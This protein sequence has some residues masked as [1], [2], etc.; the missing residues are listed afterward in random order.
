MNGVGRD[1]KKEKKAKNK[2]SV[3]TRETVGMT[4]LLFSAVIFFICVTGSRLFGEIGVAITAFFLGIGGFMT[5]PVL[6]FMIYQS[7][8]LVF[9]RGGIAWGWKFL[10][11][12]LLVCAFSIVHVSTATRFFGGGYGAY[13][14]GCWGA[15]KNGAAGGT[16]GGVLLGAIVFPVQSLLSAAG[17]YVVFA[18]LSL[19]VVFFILLK[20]PLRSYV[21]GM[22]MKQQGRF[23][24]GRYN[25]NEEFPQESSPSFDDLALPVR[26]APAQTEQPARKPQPQPSN[27]AATRSFFSAKDSFDKN[28]KE[29]SKEILFGSDPKESYRNNL[30]FNS[31]SYFNSRERA[32]SVYRNESVSSGERT[33]SS[34]YSS[35]A[36]T[37]TD[38]VPR[39][40][41]ED[42]FASQGGYTYSPVNDITYSQTPSYRVEPQKTEPDRRDYYEHDVPYREEF[43]SSTNEGNGEGKGA[44]VPEREELSR[45]ETPF[46]DETPAEDIFTRMMCEP[47]RQKGETPAERNDDFSMRSLFSRPVGEERV[48]FREEETRQT[49]ARDFPESNFG[50]R[51]REEERG[52]PRDGNRIFSR[53]DFTKEERR[54]AADLFDDENDEEDF[55]SNDAPPS[56]QPSLRQERSTPFERR[57]SE[58][59]IAPSLSE[60]ANAPKPKRHIRR[61]YIAPDYALFTKYNDKISVP[62][63]EIERNSAA[64]E[65]CLADFRVDAKVV[66]VTC[67]ATV[68]RYDLE[69]PGNISVNTVVKRDEEIAMRLHASHGVNVFANR[70]NGTVAV[71][72]P[73]ETSATV[74]LRSLLYANEYVNAKPDSLMFVVGMD[75]EGKPVIGNIVKMKQLLVAGSTGSGKSVCLHSMLI[76]LI[77]KYSPED[78]RLILIDAKGE[79]SVYENLPHLMINEIISDAQKAIMALNWAIKEMERRYALFQQKTRSGV[80][81]RNIDEYNA[82][83]TQDEEKLCKIVIMVDELADLML[84]AKKDIEERIQRLTQKS[85]AAGLH[86]VLSTQRPSVDVITGVIKGN[87]PTRMALRVVQEVDSRTIIDESGAQKL[88]GNGDMLYRTE[89]MFNC[90]RVQGAFLSS[91]EVKSIVADVKKNNE[92]YFDTEV[93]DYINN[94]AQNAS[95]VSDDEL[96]EGDGEVGEQYVKALGMVVKLGT[97]SISL[98]QRKCNVGYNHAGKIIEWMELMGYIS[99]FDGKAKARTVLLTKEEYESKYG[100]LD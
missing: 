65:E 42:K 81:V 35:A 49:P 1:E 66:K 25:P 97:A 96:E 56:R 70:A 34:R 15:A 23:G 90:L 10:G 38:P 48:S 80:L 50:G 5:Y 6:L 72:V 3:M 95:G 98:I 89:G 32:A 27:P 22:R 76:S 58:E 92:A 37:G 26:R 12:I 44:F 21:R 87:L 86:L 47:Q 82:N 78:L 8:V 39:R 63:E 84:I 61:Q 29:R 73:N 77:C 31:D 60:A 68:T 41:S 54:S 67:G 2:A 100:R 43:S 83:L 46:D 40:I 51:A 57:Q 11:G 19:L 9:G 74:G 24:R 62:Q 93:S 64:I 45:G 4:L 91:S 85:R 16:G 94:P 69:I 20:T 28:D 75:I 33:Y 52:I 7:F 55:Y 36:E 71:D 53:D 13:L 18:A 14:S 17:S 99:P 30:I 79:F 59:R 88:L